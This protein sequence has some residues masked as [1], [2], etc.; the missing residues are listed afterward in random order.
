MHRT[1]LEGRRFKVPKWRVRYAAPTDMSHDCAVVQLTRNVTLGMHEE[2][3][4]NQK[5]TL[6][7]L[8]VTADMLP[9]LSSVSGS[10]CTA[11]VGV[12]LY[13]RN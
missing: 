11:L 10:A 9:L 12:R 7:R 5:S 6:C 1:E 2:A 4:L 8:G 3:R 13:K